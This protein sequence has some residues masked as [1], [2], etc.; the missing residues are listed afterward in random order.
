MNPRNLALSLAIPA[1]LVTS[2]S[3]GPAD[4]SK[5]SSPLARA[6]AEWK[7][8]GKTNLPATTRA[9]YYL[10]A[11]ALA[12]DRLDTADAQPARTIYNH[13]AE[14]LTGLLRS[15]AGGSL[16]NRPLTLSTGTTTYHL[17][18]QPGAR[19]GIWSPGYFTGIHL[20]RDIKRGH[21]RRTVALDGIGG[22]LVGIH[23]T[24]GYGPD[25]RALFEPKR[26]LVAPVTATLDIHGRDAELTL[27][28]P[29]VRN[30]ALVKGKARPIAADF[31]A[32]VAFHPARNELVRGLKGLMHVEQTLRDS[33]LFMIHPY[34]PN[35]IPVILVHGLI[36]TP[37]MWVNVINEVEAAPNLR[38]RYQFWVFAYPTGNPPSYSALLLREQLAKAQKAYPMPHGFILIGHSMGGLLARMQATD[39][40]RA[41]WNASLGAKADDLYRKLPANHL[42]KRTLIY[43]ANPR[44][45]RIVFICVPHRG[46]GLAAGSLGEIAK[47][48]ISLPLTMVRTTTEV[49]GDIL[50]GPDGKTQLPNSITGLS[51][52]NETLRALDRLPIRA[53]YHSIIGDRGR[54]DTPDSSD[55]VVPYWSSHL[56]GAQ[57]ELIVPGPHR[58]YDIPPTIAELVRILHLH[59]G[60]QNKPERKPAATLSR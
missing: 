23:K 32:P 47:R 20:A 10:D 54:G 30:T 49:L 18:Y 9:A 14:E 52:K 58:S 1:W 29:T 24:A 26:G 36:S 41:L 42:I 4:F 25:E 53:P 57:S 44:V 56:A 37:Q 39:S 3:P 21:I 50:K 33:G 55:G 16:W 12:E 51:P 2:C 48:L 28:D 45:K 7:Y 15:A 13:S 31:T 59:L 46:S 11:A 34:D 43:H 6:S 8:A 5:L 22:T 60:L 27:T 40:G 38:G 17:R 35:R 19:G